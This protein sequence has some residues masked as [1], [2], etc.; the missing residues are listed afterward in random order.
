MKLLLTRNGLNSQIKSPF[1]FSSLK[2]GKRMLKNLQV[3][4]SVLFIRSQ[5]DAKRA[6][7][8]NGTRKGGRHD[9]GCLGVP[10]VGPI[11][12]D[13]GGLCVPPFCHPGR[14]RQRMPSP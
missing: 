10:V 12:S 7:R 2:L 13:Y 1:I 5:L 8:R 14:N 3:M 11:G 6:S 9:H 4:R